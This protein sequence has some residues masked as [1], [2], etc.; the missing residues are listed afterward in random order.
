MCSQCCQHTLRSIAHWALINLF[1]GVTWLANPCKGPARLITY[2]EVSALIEH[3][4]KGLEVQPSDTCQNDTLADQCW[5]LSELYQHL[6][7]TAVT[8]ARDLPL[9]PLH[10][11]VIYAT[12][13]HLTRV[14]DQGQYLPLL[15]GKL[16]IHSNE[17]FGA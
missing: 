12:V 4:I 2:S 13:Q 1:R 11:R 7:L 14:T 3:C 9:T 15:R 10:R 5:V 8:L 17:S 16:Q 6:D